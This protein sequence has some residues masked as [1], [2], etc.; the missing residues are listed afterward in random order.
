MDGV[1]ASPGRQRHPNGQHHVA[2]RRHQVVVV[3][4]AVH[5][6]HALIGVL[7]EGN[8]EGLGA[9][10]APEL[11]HHPFVVGEGVDGH[12]GPVSGDGASGRPRIGQAADGLRAHLLGK[13]TGREANTICYVRPLLKVIGRHGKGPSLLV[14]VGLGLT[15]DL[16]HRLHDPNRMIPNRRLGGKHHRVAAVEDRV[17][18]VTRLGAGWTRVF[19]HALEHLRGRDDGLGRLHALADE[20]LLGAGHL[21]HR[22]LD[23]KVAP[24]HHDSVHDLQNLV[25]VV[26]G[27]G[28][29]DLSNDAGLFPCLFDAVDQRLH[30]RALLHKREGHDIDLQ[31]EAQLKVFQVL[32]RHRGRGGLEVGQIYP[33]PRPQRPPFHNRRPGAA[34]RSSR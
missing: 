20:P 29:L 18:H 25:D 26:D 1:G 21:F 24:R 15:D 32:L 30:V 7:L 16:V 2:A 22:H 6:R 23:A 13:A 27:L 9:P 28:L 12:A 14:P 4:N 17:G 19:H 31:F 8:V 3:E 33:L 5:T 10:E 34:S 11:R